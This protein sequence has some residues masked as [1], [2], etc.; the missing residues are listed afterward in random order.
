M[1]TE[2]VPS[3]TREVR[4]ASR[5]TGAKATPDNFSIAEV[6]LA[7]PGP[8]E[9]VV[10]NEWLCVG[11]VGR[12]L[13]DEHTALPIPTYRIGERIWAR[14]VGTVVR[15][16]SPDLATGD[17]VEHFAGASEYSVGPAQAFFKRDRA[18]L[19]DSRYFLSQGVT[20]WHGVVDTAHVGENDVVFVSG[21]AGGVGSLAGQVA[22]LQGA[23][24]VIGSTGSQ[25]KV[26]YLIN[27]LGYDAAF[28]YRDGEIAQHLRK[29]AP[30]GISVFFDNVGGDQFL[31]ALQCA[32]WHARFALCGTLAGQSGDS[33]AGS[34]PLDLTGVISRAI[35][36]KGFAAMHTP[37]QIEHWNKQFGEWLAAKK[38]V[39]PHTTIEGLANYPQAQV[40]LLEGK[41]SGL[42][43]CRVS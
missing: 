13:M 4:L 15:S 29:L 43:L 20:A 31:A 38:I 40:A 42:V 11:A 5:P 19:P 2:A 33:T 21:A 8:G 34:P 10:R 16:N 18:V 24:K 30:E 25:A 36:I 14:A 27:E 32:T 12:D 41:Y 35:T 39:F 23:K 1:T 6:P 28:N 37:E 9:V 7:E 26:D 3:S 17:L 22:K